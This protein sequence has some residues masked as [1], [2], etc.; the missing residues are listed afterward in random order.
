MDAQQELFTALKLALEAKGYA[1][2]DGFLPPEG[3]EYPF[4]YLGDIRQD[5]TFAKREAY[6]TA[7]LVVHVF[8][9]DPKKRGTVSRM[10]QDIKRACVEIRSTANFGWM[11]RNA[12]SRIFA[13]NTTKTPLVHGV[14]EP[15]FLFS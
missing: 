11:M 5:D 10:I 1:V 13:D 9:N 2:Y 14:V 6:G 12:N 15:E 8:H 7:N 4:V 3:T